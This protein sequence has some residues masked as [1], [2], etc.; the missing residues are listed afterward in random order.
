MTHK[1]SVGR[2]VHYYEG[3]FEDPKGYSDNAHWQGTNGTRVHPAMI[4]HVHT[5]TCVNL[6]VFLDGTG[7]SVRTSMTHLPDEV[8][9]DGMH[10]TNSGWRWPERV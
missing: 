1:A 7:Q 5:D 10:C 9:V 8:F 3:D 4:T 2:I 6:I